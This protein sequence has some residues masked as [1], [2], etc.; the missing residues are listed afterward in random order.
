VNI[1]HIFF[2]ISI[3]CQQ[4]VDYFKDVLEGRLVVEH[5][6]ETWDETNEK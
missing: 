5:A 4:F 1:A 2:K 6:D 3:F